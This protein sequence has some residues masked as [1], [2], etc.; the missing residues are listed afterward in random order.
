MGGGGF[1]ID[2]VCMKK[3]FFLSLNQRMFLERVEEVSVQQKNVLPPTIL[4]IT[5]QHSTTGIEQRVQYLNTGSPLLVF[6]APPTSTLAKEGGP[7][8]LLRPSWPTQH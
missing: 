7:S 1:P 2:D 8:S 5:Q 4:Q 3:R 6:P